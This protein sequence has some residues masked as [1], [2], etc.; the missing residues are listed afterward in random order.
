MVVMGN[1]LLA[2]LGWVSASELLGRMAK[3]PIGNHEKRTR[4]EQGSD[5]DPTQQLATI[6]KVV[7]GAPDFCLF[8]GSV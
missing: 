2:F 1:V 8:G 3:T 5:L 6:P 7:V 4:W